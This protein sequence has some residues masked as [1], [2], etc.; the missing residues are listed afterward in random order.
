MRGEKKAS[1]RDKDTAR[2]IWVEMADC[3][4]TK[5]KS[6]CCINAEVYSELQCSFRLCPLINEKFK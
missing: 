3:C 1:K 2:E 4:K 5:D 6:D